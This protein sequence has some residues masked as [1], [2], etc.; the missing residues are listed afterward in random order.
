[1]K[2]KVDKDVCIGSGNCEST[3]PK[4]FKVVDGIS[5]VQV[6]PVPP[7][8]EDC[9]RDAEAGCPSGAISTE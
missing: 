7:E 1:M 5:Q 3:C 4:V 8:E 9:V 2:A 6:T